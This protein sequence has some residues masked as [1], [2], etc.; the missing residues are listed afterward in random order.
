MTTSWPRPLDST[1]EA[2]RWW[3]QHH[4]QW[5]PV[6]EELFE[7]FRR[8]SNEWRVLPEELQRLLLQR[9]GTAAATATLLD[10]GAHE[11]G[12][13]SG[14]LQQLFGHYLAVQFD[15]EHAAA[16]LLGAL[17]QRRDLHG[18]DVVTA[19][20]V[21]QYM[22]R[23]DL[24]LAHLAQCATHGA[25][26]V[27]VMLDTQGD[28]HQAWELALQQDPGYPWRYDQADVFA[29]WL[30]ANNV[31]FDSA[32]V[33]TATAVEDEQALRQVLAF[34]L[35]ANDPSLVAS[36]AERFRG[37]PTLTTAHRVFM[38]P[39]A[40]AAPARGSLPPGRTVTAPT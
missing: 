26:A 30:A 3:A 29:A 5:K 27:V 10:F 34:F 6:E 22:R 15:G 14:Q 21:V 37:R 12:L 19:V 11:G 4:L 33:W 1:T 36:V 18:F 31:P 9:F 40:A 13:L 38:F 25:I 20:H 2:G 7:P 17:P 24:A 8:R 23:P 28:Q 39:L 16:E 35:A 32:V